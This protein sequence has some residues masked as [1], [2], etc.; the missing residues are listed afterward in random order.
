MREEYGSA[1]GSGDWTAV[2]GMVDSDLIQVHDVAAADFNNDGLVD[3]ILSRYPGTEMWHQ[4]ALT[5]QTDLGFGGPGNLV[6]SVRGDDLTE[7]NS[8]ARFE[9]RGAQAGAMVNLVFST[10]NMPTPFKGGT[11]VPLPI[12]AL[13]AVPASSAGIVSD[14]LFGG[15]S[16]AVTVYAQAAYRNLS[17]NFEFSNAL[18][19]QIGF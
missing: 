10:Q 6:L 16:N 17:G 3:L 12:V 18:E 14:T 1:S 11:L 2:K 4:V 8:A 9:V 19:I 13:L 5:E 7:G 15:S